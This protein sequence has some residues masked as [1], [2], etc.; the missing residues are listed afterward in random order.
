MVQSNAVLFSQ[1]MLKQTKERPFLPG[2]V[3]R[4]SKPIFD[5]PLVEFN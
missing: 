1:F 3:V 4:V 5:L 2:E